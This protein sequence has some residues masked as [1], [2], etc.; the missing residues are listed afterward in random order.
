ML[1]NLGTT[2]L[3]ARFAATVVPRSR[4]EM[5]HGEEGER[6]VSMWMRGGDERLVLASRD[7]S[8]L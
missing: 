6:M 4:Y 3:F 5:V 7:E 2:V 1:V 8:I